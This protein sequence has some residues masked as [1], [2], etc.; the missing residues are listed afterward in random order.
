MLPGDGHGRPPL[1]FDPEKALSRCDMEVDGLA[2]FLQYHSVPFFS[3]IEELANGLEHFSDA[4]LFISRLYSTT[5]VSPAYPLK[6][7]K[8]HRISEK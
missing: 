8:R 7:P 3:S 1:S 4:D 5:H 2:V 6:P